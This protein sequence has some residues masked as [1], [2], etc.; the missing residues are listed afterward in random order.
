MALGG[1]NVIR[2]GDAQDGGADNADRRRY[3]TDDQRNEQVAQVSA[4][5]CN[6]AKRQQVAGDAHDDV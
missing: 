4:E 6:N 3:L 1:L 5:G 2:A